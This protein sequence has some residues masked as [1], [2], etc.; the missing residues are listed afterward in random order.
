[1]TS[2]LELVRQ[3]VEIMHRPEFENKVVISGQPLTSPNRDGGRWCRFD[4]GRVQTFR[5]ALSDV[6]TAEL[7]NALDILLVQFKEDI[8]R[9]ESEEE[10]ER[11][12]TLKLKRAY[13]AGNK[14][15]AIHEAGD[16]NPER[17]VTEELFAVYTK[18]EEA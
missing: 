5:D 4:N 1:M 17:T 3:D 18:K 6:S 9:R 8:E 15:R 10:R 16:L 12:I 13:K 11:N 14:L 2:A 7:F